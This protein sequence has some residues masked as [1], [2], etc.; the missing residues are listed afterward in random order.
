MA[1]VS[2]VQVNCGDD[3]E[4]S[5]YY[6][7]VTEVEDDEVGEVLFESKTQKEAIDW[8]KNS[9]YTVNIH[10]VRKRSNGDQYGRY[11]AHS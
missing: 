4:P 7:V 3:W 9:S 8:A 5:I 6:Q 2:I 1:D 10:R 11:R